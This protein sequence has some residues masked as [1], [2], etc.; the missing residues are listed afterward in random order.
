M[1]ISV[2][3][4]RPVAMGLE[5]KVRD[6]KRLVISRDNQVNICAFGDRCLQVPQSIIELSRTN[7]NLCIYR[8]IHYSNTIEEPIRL[9]DRFTQEFNKYQ[10]KLVFEIIH[11]KKENEIYITATKP[12]VNELLHRINALN[13]LKMDKIVFNLD[14]KKAENILN[15]YGKW[16]KTDKGNIRC[17]AEF[18]YD[19]NT[20]PNLGEVTTLNMR[21]RKSVGECDITISKHGQISSRTKSV[22]VNDIISFYKQIKDDLLSKTT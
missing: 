2:A 1:G 14:I 19:V 16:M 7:K 5:D 15:I 9:W 3:F 8:V 21:V 17:T 4:L 6:K 11:D 22:T 12:T 20:T 10:K 13:Y 18:G